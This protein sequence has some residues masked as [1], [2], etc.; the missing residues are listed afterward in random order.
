MIAVLL[1]WYLFGLHDFELDISV[2]FP[3]LF[4]FGSYTNLTDLN[5]G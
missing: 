3:R 5:I 4:R 1:L 2:P